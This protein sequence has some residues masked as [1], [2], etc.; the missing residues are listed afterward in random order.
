MHKSIK[1]FILF[2]FLWQTHAQTEIKLMSYNLL[3]FP[4][5]TTYDRTDDLRYILDSYQPDIFMVCELE[6]DTGSDMILN[7]CLNYNGDLYRGASFRENES[8]NYRDLQQMLYYNRQKFEL[9]YETSLL[10][11]I[12]DINHYVLKMRNVDQTNTPVYID[13]YVA[14]LKASGGTDNELTRANMVQVFT[15]DLQ[16]IPP[17][18]Y[19]I[20][21][22]DFNLY[23]SSEPA[24]Q[25][26]IDNTNAIIMHDPANSPGSWHNNYDFRALHTQ[27]T[28]SQSNNIFVGG[29]ID[30]RFDFIMISDNMLNDPVLHYVD[31]TYKS[32]GNNGNC[33]N[34]AVTNS[35]CDSAEYDFTL[36]THLYNMS[37]HLPVV[38]KLE[39]NQTINLDVASYEPVSAYH[40]VPNLVRNRLKISG[41]ENS[42]LQLSIFDS[43]GKQ[44]I[45]L[46]AYQTFT[47]IGT[48]FLRPGVY[49]IRIQ[50]N[51]QVQTLKFVKTD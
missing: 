14:H 3:H 43:T 16:N 31:D 32:Y 42:I 8:S 2:L 24:Y 6:S 9:T 37:D 26:I 51:N 25:K 41:K 46:P 29:G 48:D 19:V 1:L 28:H 38:M 13:I 33:F 7:N 45:S 35:D 49:F 20:F 11:Q 17:D 12:R 44:V 40:V 27:A 21:A 5:G 23:S 4:T 47:E 34:K 15:D 30:D 18:H 36:R 39:T 10:T 50:E 22:G